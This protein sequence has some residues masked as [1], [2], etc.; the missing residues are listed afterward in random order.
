MKDQ[1]DLAA[2]ETRR[3]ALVD[4]KKIQ[5]HRRIELDAA[6][7]A[8]AE[9]NRKQEEAAREEK[10]ASLEGKSFLEAK[11]VEVSNNKDL[12]GAL[13]IQTEAGE[14]AWRRKMADM[15][16]EKR[17]AR[18][19]LNQVQEFVE[20]LKRA[21]FSRQKEIE[22]VKQQVDDLDAVKTDLEQ[23]RK[24]AR[25]DIAQ[26]NRL[27][28]EVEVTLEKK[29]AAEKHLGVLKKIQ[30]EKFGEEERK[31]V[32]QGRVQVAS[33]QVKLKKDEL[34]VL[35]S[36]S[37]SE[38]ANLQKLNNES[39]IMKE[40]K[41]DYF[42]KNEKLHNMVMQNREE[43]KLMF[44]MEV[45]A[46]EEKL[47]ILQGEN[48]RLVELVEAQGKE[49]LDAGTENEKLE[50]QL[51]S[52]EAEVTEEMQSVASAKSK[53]ESQVEVVKNL[54][55]DIERLRCTI[56]PKE[57]ELASKKETLNS[58]ELRLKQSG[59][60]RVLAG[61]SLAA[62]MKSLNMIEL[63][64]QQLESKTE[65][66]KNLEAE[67]AG[68][69]VEA[70]SM[71]EQGERNQEIK[72]E[73]VEN[74]KKVKKL[75]KATKQLKSEM[76][77]VSKRKEKLE[78]QCG[79]TRLEMSNI[80]E[81]IH[82]VESN[83]GVSKKSIEEMSIAEVANEEA[84]LKGKEQF[85]QIKA[86]SEHH[87]SQSQVLKSKTKGL[88]DEIKKVEGLLRKESSQVEEQKM[89]LEEK[90]RKGDAAVNATETESSDHDQRLRMATERLVKSQGQKKELTVNL[91]KVKEEN[92][93]MAEEVEEVEKAIN[94][95]TRGTLQQVV[96][97][98]PQIQ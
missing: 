84:L 88:K 65:Q 96:L 50:H 34:T 33:E 81:E 35:K 12:L 74:M 16:E 37:E 87:A 8:S 72:S 58:L 80:Q 15:K 42:I 32:L 38:E 27:G 9:N 59:D 17:L 24:N 25:E 13:L 90:Q 92:R 56:Q 3:F 86:E 30:Q 22:D 77:V 23:R 31:V 51:S 71:L 19:Q 11:V 55:E 21:A 67:V 29:A 46:M 36:Q 83:L 60:E 63:D 49:V 28:K 85:E 68:Q 1:E 47:G 98:E 94:S 44:D 82:Q 6:I 66:L 26:L 52:K 79:K 45:K 5:S 2:V 97:S 48:R 78:K 62:D 53:K 4:E 20:Q 7:Q 73:H 40:K 54:S 95:L 93:S 14:D 18:H 89:M 76:A 69:L 57:D 91:D 39:I 10:Q 75:Q 43:K 70:S 61:K 64:I 41:Q